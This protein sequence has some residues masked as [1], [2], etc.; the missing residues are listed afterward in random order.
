[1][2]FFT[3]N[4]LFSVVSVLVVGLMLISISYFIQGNVLVG[5][6]QNKTE[7]VAE[8][9]YNK[10]SAEDVKTA[11]GESDINS[12]V[13]KEFREM[14]NNLSM[15]NKTVAQGYVFG[16]ELSGDDKNETSVIAFPD[17][18][19]DAFKEA[20]LEVG[21]MYPQPKEIAKSVSVLKETGEMQ[22]TDVYSDDYGTWLTIMYPIKDGGDV[23]AYYAIDVDASSIQ[24]GQ[25]GLVK[26]MVGVLLVLLLIVVSIQ[27]VLLKRSMKP[28][29]FLM[30]G[31]SDASKGN[32][33]VR[34]EEGSDELGQVNASFNVMMKSLGDIVGGVKE[35]AVEVKGSAD[36]LDSSFE[37]VTLASRGITDAVR[38]VEDLLKVQSASVEESA[39][40]M[41][42]ISEQV[43]LIGGNVTSVYEHSDMVSKLT[44]S[45]KE[46]TDRVVSQMGV[47][48]ENVKD[49]E[50]VIKELVMI[51]EDIGEFLG[52]IQN[53][54]AETNLLA[55]NAAIEAARAGEAGRGFAVV[56]SEVKKLSEQ[57]SESVEGI[58]ELVKQVNLVVGKTDSSMSSIKENVTSGQKIS[59]ETSGIFGEIY[60]STNG[61]TA[62]L[63]EIASSA[64][65]VTAS[66]EEA[67]SMVVELSSS[68]QQVL[69]G[70]ELIVSNVDEQV[71][72]LESVREMS[73]NMKEYVTQLDESVKTFSVTK[74]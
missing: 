37:V 42:E 14:F 5:Q 38:E 12:D 34:I 17:H 57:S 20:G 53:I 48:F 10:I 32:L 67:T 3:K 61:V 74:K 18:V 62:K 66:V 13:H 25:I 58:R 11:L 63:Q 72:S 4:L 71:A 22:F 6:L 44:E 30:H 47:I 21:S 8:V 35:T 28:L 33:D 59:V 65:Q 36:G 41:G 24:D 43:Q 50:Q 51:T 16:A 15:Y 55:L 56:A 68:S 7:E 19:W 27:Y 31:I 29:E 23:I 39:S 26:W 69:D 49:S 46:Y 2:K 45:G 9:W 1:M 40:T 73:S 64:E 70:Y 52:V 54:S 60:D